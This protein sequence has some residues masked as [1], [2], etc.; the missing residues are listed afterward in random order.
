L[1][2]EH[3]KSNKEELKN[4]LKE[5]NQAVGEL[6]KTKVRK[7][8][9]STANYMRPKAPCSKINVGLGTSAPEL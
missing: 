2:I 3:L 7:K 1:E 8:F 4:S 6:L 9:V 5:V